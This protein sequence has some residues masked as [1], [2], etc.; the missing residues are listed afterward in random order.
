MGPPH[1]FRPYTETRQT[2]LN[3]MIKQSIGSYLNLSSFSSEEKY[4]WGSDLQRP[5][6]V[7]K[8]L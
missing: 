7:Y 8:K 3:L 5:F 2:S 4:I 6:Q 1:I